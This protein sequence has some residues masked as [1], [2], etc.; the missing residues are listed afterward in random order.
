MAYSEGEGTG[1]VL[2]G[3][4]A[5]RD[6]VDDGEGS[7]GG[8]QGHYD[9]LGKLAGGLGTKSGGTNRMVGL[10]ASFLKPQHDQTTQFTG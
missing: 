4:V 9:Y 2:D 7:D 5:V 10:G 1:P 6:D 3:L 8:G